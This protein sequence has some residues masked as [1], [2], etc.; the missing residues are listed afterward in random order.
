M[1]FLFLEPILNHKIGKSFPPQKYIPVLITPNT[2]KLTSFKMSSIIHT[3]IH[4][5]T[6]TKTISPIFVY[7]SALTWKVTDA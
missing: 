2:S 7:N 3:V 5:G 1:N 6:R 4:F